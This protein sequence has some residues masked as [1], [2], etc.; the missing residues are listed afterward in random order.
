MQACKGLDVGAIEFVQNTLLELRSMGVAILYV[1]TELE[2]V[3]EVSD[4]VSVI[5]RGRITGTV[6]VSEASAA[7]IGELMGGLSEAA[8]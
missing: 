2:H 6:P 7:R 1:S 5:F 3:L 8:A 4:R